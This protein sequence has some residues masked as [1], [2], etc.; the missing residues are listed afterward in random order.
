M[1]HSAA[2]FDQAGR[3]TGSSGSVDTV[4]EVE[5]PREV[6]GHLTL[7]L[8]VTCRAFPPWPQTLDGTNDAQVVLKDF[9]ALTLDVRRRQ[10]RRLF[11]LPDWNRSERMENRQFEAKLR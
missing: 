10:S 7:Q 8:S 1:I 11:K 6:K 4:Q 9:R 5:D 3:E 2:L